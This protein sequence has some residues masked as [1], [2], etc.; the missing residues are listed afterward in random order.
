MNQ[1]DWRINAR[2]KNKKPRFQ[3]AKNRCIY[4]QAEHSIDMKMPNP[5]HAKCGKITGNDG[6]NRLYCKYH[7]RKMGG[8][9]NE[10]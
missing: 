6:Q 9:L 2:N 3:R 1:P 8:G 5:S 10:L 4:N 7:H